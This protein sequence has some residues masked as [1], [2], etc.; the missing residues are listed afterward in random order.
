MS[1]SNVAV[2]SS[3][4]TRAVTQWSGKAVAA[5][6]GKSTM[7]EALRADGVVSDDLVYVKGKE[8][9]VLVKALKS[10]I[11]AGWTTTVQELLK[12]D[13]KTLSEKQKAERRYWMQQI[14]S[15]IKDVRNALKTKE[16]GAGKQR[17]LK[18]LINA[19][20]TKRMTQVQADE[21]PNYDAV[22]LLKVLAIVAKLTK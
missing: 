6:K 21:K 22:E 19:E 18:Q 11:V 9:T 17:T 10:A 7:V 8:D 13:V 15:K 2:L 20:A 14:G 1:K 12:K 4:A 3:A 16:N 5:D